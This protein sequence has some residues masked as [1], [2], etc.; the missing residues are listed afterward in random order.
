MFR[1]TNRTANVRRPEAFLYECRPERDIA[2][3]SVKYT[4]STHFSGLFLCD[5]TLI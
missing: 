1:D 5:L 2:L 4:I 3:L